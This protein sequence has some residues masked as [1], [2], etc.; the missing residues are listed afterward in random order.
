MGGPV[1]NGSDLADCR[2]FFDTPTRSRNSRG[3]VAELPGANDVYNVS[4]QAWET[5]KKGE[6]PYVPLLGVAGRLGTVTVRCVSPETAFRLLTWLSDEQWN[7]QVCASS[8]DTT[9]FRRSATRFAQAWTEK[10]FSTPAAAEYAALTH[11]TL[12]RQQWAF[13]LRIPGRTQYLAVLDEAVQK[14][15]RGQDKPQDALRNVSAQWREIG[16]PPGTRS[17]ARSLPAQPGT[18][19]C[20]SRIGT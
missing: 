19:K 15:L 12:S 7:R 17:P 9:L 18:L 16:N 13:A 14:V 8:P 4:S 5:R 20:L 11:Q 6:D 10:P 1:R 2:R 3:C